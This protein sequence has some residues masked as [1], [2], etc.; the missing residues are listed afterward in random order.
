MPLNKPKLNIHPGQLRK[1]RWRISP[2]LPSQ[3]MS[4]KKKVLTG[5]SSGGKRLGFF[6]FFSHGTFII[7]MSPKTDKGTSFAGPGDNAC[8]HSRYG[9]IEQRAEERGSRKGTAGWFLFPSA[10]H[11]LL[12]PINTSISGVSSR[13]RL[14]GNES[15]ASCPAF[16]CHQ[17]D[18]F[19]GRT[20]ARTHARLPSRLAASRYKQR[21]V[22]ISRARLHG[23]RSGL[24]GLF[25]FFVALCFLR[26][27]GG[28]RLE[29]NEGRRGNKYRKQTRTPGERGKNYASDG[30]TENFE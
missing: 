19:S 4:E 14:N 30:W 21:V 3:Q 28:Q 2:P 29:G 20:H 15:R 22:V 25:F 13:R 12:F 1:K 10:F 24:G 6:F 17:R 5:R 9:K 27:M 7:V 23:G 26:W 16:G 11:Y 18:A 8:V